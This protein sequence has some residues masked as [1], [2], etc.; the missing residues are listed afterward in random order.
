MYD[1]VIHELYPE[2]LRCQKLLTTIHPDLPFSYRQEIFDA[3]SRKCGVI[4]D[5]CLAIE[6]GILHGNTQ[7]SPGGIDREIDRREESSKA[8]PQVNNKA[9]VAHAVTSIA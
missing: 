5:G 1:P 9:H 2:I 4:G 7:N 3:R 6:D 8:A